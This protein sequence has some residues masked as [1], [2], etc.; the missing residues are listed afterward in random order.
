MPEGKTAARAARI[1]RNSTST[2]REES[3]DLTGDP[4]DVVT[5]SEIPGIEQ[6]L[7]S[8]GNHVYLEKQDRLRDI[9]VDIQ[10]SQIVVVGS[11]SS[12]KSS[13]LENLT[14]FSF[15]RGQG[16]CTRY[17]TQITLRRNPIESIVISI[18]PSNNATQQTKDRIRAFHRELG[19]FEG[20]SLAAVIEDANKV[21]GI[22]SGDTEDDLSLPMFSNDILKI[23]ISGPE[24][25]H[26]TVIDVPG[27]F[28]VT[29]EGRTTERDKAMVENMVRRVLAVLSCLADRAT[30]GVLQ[31][32]KTADPEGERTVGVLTK[33]DLVKEKA[34]LRTIH[35]LVS[36]D[37]LKLGYFVVRNRG[38]DED[39]LDV[40]KCNVKEE[41][42]FNQSDWDPI[43]KLGR[44]GVQAL[45]V[46]LQ[47]LLL[48]LAKRELPKQRAEVMKRLDD[49]RQSLNAM[50]AARP[51]APSQRE[52]L[53]KLTLKF[54]RIVRDALEGLYEGDQLFKNN[55]ELRLITKVVDLNE[56]FSDLMAAKGH[57]FTFSGSSSSISQT[58]GDD[59]DKHSRVVAY[60]SAVAESFNA[61]LN[62]TELSLD[63][64]KLDCPSPAANMILNK[65]EAC[66]RETRG[67]ELGTFGGSLLSRTFRIQSEKWAHIVHCHV[68]AVIV[69]VHR[70]IRS[71]LRAVFPD[72]RMREELW[73]SI[74][75]ERVQ[76]AYHRALEQAD[77]LIGI[78]ANGRPS[79]YNHYFNDNLQK[80]RVERLS[81]GIGRVSTPLNDNTVN[82]NLNSLT[83]LVENKSNV[84]QVKEDVHDILK[85]YYKV[86]RKR[87]VDDIC[88]QVINHFLLDG[89]YSPLRVLS[90]EVI[91]G[92]TDSQ[93][94]RIAGESR[95]TKRERD[96]LVSEVKGLEEAMEVLRS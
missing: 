27:L 40:S 52:C 55:M 14:G 26:L 19:S 92:L 95:A 48:D 30:E 25:P 81:K 78:E 46:E 66:Y 74:L 60:Q 24:K 29:D 88:L 12:G 35:E 16:L 58:P 49:C 37:T 59:D 23:E 73:Q 75:L 3:I 2:K 72:K 7:D 36:G 15:P 44:T 6:S 53:V 8:L 56:G 39:D 70:F 28:Q 86:A 17:A 85:S 83:S 45:K 51:D 13:L 87:F 32:A 4:D 62:F 50:G 93:L 34:V 76:R 77:F 68:N 33:A 84:D 10:T 61:G 9:G 63:L 57:A 47:S 65:I 42:L 41:A 31:F 20:T 5:V 91:M 43:A 94:D 69:V 71:L 1:P 22:R 64:T 11:Q 54:E 21:M 82:L 80:A 89:P 90:P 96:R 79:T 38:A 18:T 67:P